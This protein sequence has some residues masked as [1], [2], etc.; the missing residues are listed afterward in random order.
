M[1]DLDD[2]TRAN[3]RHA[4][5]SRMLLNPLQRLRDALSLSKASY[6][7]VPKTD[8]EHALGLI[9]LLYEADVR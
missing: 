8:L 7:M 4:A 9:K 6:V 3:A 1:T 2:W 5:P